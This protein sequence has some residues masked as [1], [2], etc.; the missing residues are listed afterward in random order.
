[1]AF[2]F[3]PSPFPGQ[4]LTRSAKYRPARE[5][6]A[7][8]RRLNPLKQRFM[9]MDHPFIA[10]FLRPSHDMTEVRSQYS[11]P[12]GLPSCSISFVFP[13]TLCPV[14]AGT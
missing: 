11:F 5:G 14:T 3:M 6:H 1:M 9:E 8:K 4:V 7:I 10:L 13:F 12:I 2:S